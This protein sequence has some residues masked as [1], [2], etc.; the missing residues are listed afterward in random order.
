M[1]DMK[2]MKDM[3]SLYVIQASKAPETLVILQVPTSVPQFPAY[4]MELIRLAE[5]G[6]PTPHGPPCTPSA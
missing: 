6:G 1:K 3:T 5:A 2:D 4:V